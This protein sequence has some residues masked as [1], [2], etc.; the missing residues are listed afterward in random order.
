MGKKRRDSGSNAAK[1]WLKVSCDG[2]PEGSVKKVFSHSSLSSPY[3]VMSFQLSAP[4][5]T[6][7]TLLDA[8]HEINA[9]YG[10]MNIIDEQVSRSELVGL[11]VAVSIEC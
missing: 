11:N 3:S 10:N 8:V 5:N 9:S 4:L 6:A 1:T 2:M 7:A